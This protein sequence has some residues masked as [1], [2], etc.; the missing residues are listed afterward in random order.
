MWWTKKRIDQAFERVSELLRE[1]AL[2][3]MVFGVLDRV[4]AE[5][6]T[7]IWFLSNV[8]SSVAIWVLG[9]YIELRRID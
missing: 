7:A 2:L 9:V 4:V 6:L 3:W 8:G 1:G 5:R